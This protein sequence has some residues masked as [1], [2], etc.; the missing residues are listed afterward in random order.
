MR[1]WKPRGWET[2]FAFATGGPHPALNKNRGLKTP[3]VK[4]AGACPRQLVLG[5][6][7][8]PSARGL[9]RGQWQHTESAPNVSENSEKQGAVNEQ[10]EAGHLWRGDGGRDVGAG[11]QEPVGVAFLRPGNTQ[12]GSGREHWGHRGRRRHGQPRV[13]PLRYG[14][15][16]QHH[17]VG[18]QLRI[19]RGYVRNGTWGRL[20]SAAHGQ[21]RG[22]TRLGSVRAATANSA[23]ALAMSKW[24]SGR[25]LARQT[26]SS[27]P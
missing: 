12:F 23:S 24:I 5:G 8:A 26:A 16:G 9:P 19:K 18:D 3:E 14:W 22:W 21:Q 7:K 13:L 10:L 4:V 27:A 1:T 6:N 2:L 25:L 20:W 17:S 11:L 15:H